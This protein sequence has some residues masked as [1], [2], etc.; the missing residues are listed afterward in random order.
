M[1]NAWNSKNSNVYRGYF[2]VIETEPSRKEG[3]EFGRDVNPKDPTIKPG[4]WFYEASVWPKEDGKFPFKAFLT[5]TYEYMHEMAMEV[6]RLAARGL[7]IDENAFEPIFLDK[8]LSTFRLIHYPPWKGEPSKNAIVEDG[9]FV[10]SPDHTDSNFLT[11]LTTFN[12]KG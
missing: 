12:Y 10:T 4:N 8:P 11:L 7:G 5:E 6:L 1:K 3:F 2:P 9:K